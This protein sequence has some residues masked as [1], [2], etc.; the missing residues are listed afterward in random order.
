MYV[1]GNINDIFVMMLV[2]IGVI[3]IL[4]FW[5]KFE[6]INKK[7]KIELVEMN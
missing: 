3:V 5:E 1:R 4:V 7:C 6:V 2:D